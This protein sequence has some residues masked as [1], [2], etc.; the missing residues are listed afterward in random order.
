MEY[1]G[2]RGRNRCEPSGLQAASRRDLH[3]GGAHNSHRPGH[4]LQQM[5]CQGR[6]WRR[7]P[8]V[9]G[10]H[11]NLRHGDSQRQ[12]GCPG[13]RRCRVR[14]EGSAPPHCD[15][16]R[17]DSRPCRGR[18]CVHRT[19]AVHGSSQRLLCGRVFGQHC[20]SAVP[21][22]R[23]VAGVGRPDRLPEVRR[24]PDPSGSQQQPLPAMPQHPNGSCWLRFH[25]ARDTSRVH[26]LGL[27]F[28]FWS[29]LYL[30]WLGDGCQGEHDQPHGLVPLPE[31]G[32]VPR[33]NLEGWPQTGG[34]RAHAA[35]PVALQLGQTLN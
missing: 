5:S 18:T 2:S 14:E 29:F 9:S 13:R 31:H 15:P 34:R 22:R 30:F 23:R 26:G 28:S 21:T 4:K 8:R 20:C 33:W 16:G 10:T 12:H 19:T 24:G 3:R 32:H 6:L 25:G 27:G 17:Q 1:I 7:F 35:K 11:D